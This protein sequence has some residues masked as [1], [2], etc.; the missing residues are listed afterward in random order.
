MDISF[1]AL[2]SLIFIFS[3]ESVPLFLNLFS[4]SF[5]LGGQIKTANVLLGNSFFIDSQPIASISK[6]KFL[7]KLFKS[8]IS[9]FKVP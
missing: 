6:I 2:E 8:F 1:E 3:S 4:N 7:P 9:D 5:K